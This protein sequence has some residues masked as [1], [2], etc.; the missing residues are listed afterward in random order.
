MPRLTRSREQRR[1]PMRQVGLM[2]AGICGLMLAPAAP[3]GSVDGAAASPSPQGSPASSWAPG[4]LLEDDFTTQR[5]DPRPWWIGSDD[6]ASSAYVDGGMRWQLHQAG[7]IWDTIGFGQDSDRV[8]VSAEVVVEQGSGGGG[9]VCGTGGNE[10]GRYL[11]AGINGD[12]EWL[13][14][15][16]ID[17]HLHISAR[18][19]R[20]I[21]RRHDVPTGDLIPWRVTLECSTD[22]LGDGDHMT[23]W[24]QD[25]QVADVQ[26]EQ[27]G[28]YDLAGLAAA[29]DG[30]GFAI[31][32]DD[33][34]A[35]AP[36]VVTPTVA[37]RR[38]PGPSE[39]AAPS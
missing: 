14:G 33:F 35:D 10:D 28:P 3:V 36:T 26:D 18:G 31:V 12:G 22:P 23:V 39:S 21:I 37:P 2:L 19:E 4:H 9:P 6:F 13:V 8:R 24:I 16:I 34:A 27:V 25:V 5:A 29:S 20:P 30:P 1:I 38:P 7:L 11:W 15:R 32:F 17:R